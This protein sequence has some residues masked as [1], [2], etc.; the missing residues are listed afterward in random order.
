MSRD[1]AGAVNIVSK[2]QVPSFNALAFMVFE[3]LEEK[4]DSASYLIN[5]KG[6]CKNCPG[7]TG[8]VKYL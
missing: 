3:D 6:V 5:N 8:S 1:T 2:L 7:Y 4:D